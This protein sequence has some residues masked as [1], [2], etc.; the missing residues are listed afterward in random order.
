MK[1]IWKFPLQETDEQSFLMPEGAQ[2]L[3]VEEQPGHGLQ[4]WALVDP[5]KS[6][7]QRTFQMYGTGHDIPDDPGT[8]IKTFFTFGGRLVFHL[9]ERG[10]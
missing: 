10:R 7:E 3:H 8:H 1:T 5:S 6:R 4:L 9:F 2:V